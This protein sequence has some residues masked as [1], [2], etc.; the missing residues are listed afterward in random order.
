MLALHHC[1]S[2]QNK[3]YTKLCIAQVIRANALMTLISEFQYCVID[4]L[5]ALINLTDEFQ[6]CVMCSTH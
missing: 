6:Y 1:W 3:D 5:M 4:A 2:H